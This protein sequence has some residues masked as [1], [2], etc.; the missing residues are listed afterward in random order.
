MASR[1]GAVVAIADA[2]SDTLIT[3]CPEGSRER[4]NLEA[5]RSVCRAMVGARTPTLPTAPLVCERGALRNPEFPSVQTLY[6]YYRG[7]LKIWRIAFHEVLDV[8]ADRPIG[9]D[10]VERIDTSN[11]DSSTSFVVERLKEIVLELTQRCNVLKHIIDESVPVPAGD[12]PEDASQIVNALAEW[13]RSMSS[14]A[15]VLD[16]F[17]LKVSRRTPIGT[18][19]MDADLFNEL[20]R[21]V[22]DFQNVQR[23]RKAS[24]TN[25]S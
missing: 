24:G 13:T 11:M 9:H 8:D 21:F 23:A 3:A 14:G 16:D 2:K 10:E 20:S 6:N 22:D 4:A 1:K 19:I 15:F 7:M 12:L 25:S 5:I 17:G 18:R